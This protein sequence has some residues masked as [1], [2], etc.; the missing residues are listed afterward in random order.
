MDGAG[1]RITSYA[2]RVIRVKRS[3]NDAVGI[4]KDTVEHMKSYYSQVD[5]KVVTSC[6]GD[7]MV[8]QIAPSIENAFNIVLDEIEKE[9]FEKVDHM[10]QI[11]QDIKH[12]CGEFHNEIQKGV[13][14]RGVSF[15]ELIKKK[16]MNEI[17]EYV[18]KNPTEEII[19]SFLDHYDSSLLDSIEDIVMILQL[20]NLV[21]DI[22]II[23][24]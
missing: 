9:W 19:N 10:K 14:V 24:E 3:A 5:E 18:L 6:I 4:L 12:E 1:S 21:K 11:T 16:K 17:I 23:N 7:C 22:D 13:S 8:N 2:K 15:E 20:A